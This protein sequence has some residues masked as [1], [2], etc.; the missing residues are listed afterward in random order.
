MKWCAQLVR[1]AID[2][3]AESETTPAESSKILPSEIKFVITK[4]TKLIKIQ[5]H[6]WFIMLI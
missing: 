5:E 6:L 4:I 3:F 2:C 1:A